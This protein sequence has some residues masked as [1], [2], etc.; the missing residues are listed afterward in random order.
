MRRPNHPT[1]KVG[2]DA[3]Q[4]AIDDNIKK[5]IGVFFGGGIYAIVIP[6]P[7]KAIDL[8]GRGGRS[9]DR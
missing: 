3:R 9:F 1:S 8:G 7:F 4:T 6:E 2:D 5:I